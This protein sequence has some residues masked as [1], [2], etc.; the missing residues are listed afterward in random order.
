M[1]NTILNIIRFVI[2]LSL[3]V[4]IFNNIDLL[5]YINPYPYVLFILL[6]P[7]NGNKNILLISSFMLGLLLDMFCNSGGI[8]AMASLILAF[9]R[10]SLFRFSF[11]LSYEY[12][13]VKIADKISTERITFILFSIFIHHFVLFTFELFR[14]N[15]FFDIISR[16]LLT[17][18]LTF[19]FCL[20]I[21][22]LIKPSKR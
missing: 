6:Y 16:T 9:V 4:L 13:T 17:T 10:P 8:H 7:V 21:I 12:Q 5:G 11:G 20:L 14:I 3:Q 2:L 19:A 22:Y 1:N 15:L 18:L